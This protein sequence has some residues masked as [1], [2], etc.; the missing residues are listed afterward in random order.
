MTPRPQDPV[1]KTECSTENVPETVNV[2]HAIVPF[3]YF[4]IASG[5]L[6]FYNVFKGYMKILV[7]WNGLR[8]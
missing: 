5:D 4:L 7:A 3:H 2:S 8:I 1:T 6:W